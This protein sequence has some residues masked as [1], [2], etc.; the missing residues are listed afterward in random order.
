MSSYFI[1]IYFINSHLSNVVA[2]CGIPAV[3]NELHNSLDSASYLSNR[4]L[5]LTVSSETLFGAEVH[6]GKEHKILNMC[7]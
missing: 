3:C 1:C 2:V 6:R 5:L 7:C 4:L